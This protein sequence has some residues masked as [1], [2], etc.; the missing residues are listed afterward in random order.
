MKK[1]LLL[2]CLSIIL[3]GCSK[4]YDGAVTAYE[5]YQLVKEKMKAEKYVFSAVNLINLTT[6]PN[7]LLSSLPKELEY[8]HKYGDLT[9]KMSFSGKDIGKA[10]FWLYFV[11]CNDK[12]YNV[13][14]AVKDGKPVVDIYPEDLPPLSQ[15]NLLNKFITLTKENDSPV[16]AKK[17]TESTKFL[18]DFKAKNDESLAVILFS[19]ISQY[20]IADNLRI[21]ETI[22]YWSAF[23]GDDPKISLLLA[24]KNID[25][26]PVHCVIQNY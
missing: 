22:P 15:E 13:V 16:F 2:F 23:M 19:Y 10:N 4:E 1:F 6:L 12:Y 21:N 14:C 11:N 5:G 8:A 24:D 3:F 18:D 25:K 20:E 26:N 9:A 17:L 7:T